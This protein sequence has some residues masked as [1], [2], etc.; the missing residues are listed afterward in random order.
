MDVGGCG[1]GLLDG[2]LIAERFASLRLG[3]LIL[4]AFKLLGIGQRAVPLIAAVLWSSAV[5]R[6]T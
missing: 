2:T 5:L 6:V 3:F 4:V 1:I